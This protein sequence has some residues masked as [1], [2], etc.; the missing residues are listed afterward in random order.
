METKRKYF[1]T[2]G[3]RGVA[4]VPPLD[5]ETLV[6]LG[7]A[8]AQVFLNVHK[9]RRILIGKDTRLSGYMIES[10]LAAGITAMGADLMLVGPI[11]TPGVAYLTKSM[12]A[13]AGI[14]IS[15]SHNPFEDNGI[16]FFSKTGHKLPDAV[17]DEIAAIVAAPIDYT[18]APTGSTLGRV[19]EER[20]KAQLYINHI[21]NSASYR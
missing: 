11:P 7:K 5:P 8:V 9:K 6:R 15:A 1:G 20:D 13:D 12:R 3:I 21:V 18:H 16:K 19:I 10:S 4:S 17:E 2:D 14:M